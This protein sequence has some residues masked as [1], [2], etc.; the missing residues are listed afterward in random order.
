MD[1]IS[2]DFNHNKYQNKSPWAIVL[3]FVVVIL[4]G[5]FWLIEEKKEVSYVPSFAQN[6]SP[7]K[8]TLD[9]A[10]DLEASVGS[11]EIPNY[12]DSE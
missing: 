9:I 3:I 6:P 10:S 2:K 8:S 4:F 5:I 11:I 7:K 12:S 1:Q